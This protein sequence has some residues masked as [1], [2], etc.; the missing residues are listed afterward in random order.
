MPMMDE[1]GCG[2]RMMRNLSEKSPRVVGLWFGFLTPRGRLAVPEYISID[3]LPQ[4]QATEY[5]KYGQDNY[6]SGEK[7][8]EHT[9]EAIFERAFP[10]KQAVFLFDNASNH[11]TYAPDA[12]LGNMN[13]GPSGKQGIV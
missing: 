11:N 13:L 12:L 7:M 3:G 6:W 4:R 8:V 1:D 9:L 2:F 10:G 5:L